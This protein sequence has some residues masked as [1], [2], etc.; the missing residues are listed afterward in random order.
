LPFGKALTKGR[1]PKGAGGGGWESRV[2]GL[3]MK[4]SKLQKIKEVDAKY[5][6]K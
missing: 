4:G 6:T 3:N 5:F 2:K 1:F